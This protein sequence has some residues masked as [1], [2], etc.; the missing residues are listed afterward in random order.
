MRHAGVWCLALLMVAAPVHAGGR[1]HEYH[2]GYWRHHG[3]HRHHHHRHGRDGA[4][5]L[6]GI[7]IGTVLGQAFRSARDYYP[8]EPVR[9]HGYDGPVV[10]RRLY[11]DLD[12]NC[13]ERHTDDAGRELLV[14]LPAWECDW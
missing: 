4:Y 12:G 5:L 1:R 14:E 2:D 10:A 6:G 11:R 13:F 9:R 8:A 7:V 3:H